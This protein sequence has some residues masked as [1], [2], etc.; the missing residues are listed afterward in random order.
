[1]FPGN[2]HW[3]IYRL[4]NLH[5]LSWGP[6]PS[7]GETSIKYG[8]RPLTVKVATDPHRE[9]RFNEEKSSRPRTPW[10]ANSWMKASFPSMPGMRGHRAA[11]FYPGRYYAN[12]IPRRLPLASPV[13]RA[14][15]LIPETQFG[16]PV[17]AAELITRLS[18][19]KN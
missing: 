18:P 6:C 7:E 9:E 3:P 5:V 12:T 1:M 16:M 15:C 13:T 14:G 4:A 8:W 17:V 10:A 19:K 2:R 11:P